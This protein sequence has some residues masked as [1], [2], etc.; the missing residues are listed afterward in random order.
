MFTRRTFDVV[1]VG[2]GVVGAACAFYTSRSGLC[3]AVVDRG[4]V[5]G[6]TTGA[7]E[8]NLLVSDKQPGPELDLAL[9]STRLW[10]E[11]AEEFPATFEYEAKGG[12]V[13][14]AQQ[15]GLAA[16]RTFAATQAAAGVQCEDVPHL[17]DVEPHLAPGLA[18]G[19][20]YPQDAQVQPALAAAHLLRASGARLLLG[21]EVIGVLR[22]TDGAVRGVR[23]PRGDL[24]APAVVNA[25]GTWG[26]QVAE[27]AGT[28]LP[29]LP[30]RGFVLVT[31]P[32]PRVVRHK[33]Y[34]ADY[35]ADVASGSAA[36]QTS[37]VVEGT[38]AG[39]VLIGASRERV[40]FD[41]SLST[42]VLGKLAR[43]AQELFPVLRGV[44]VMRTYHGFR[45]YLPDHHPAIG[46]DGRVPGLWH[47]CGHEGAGVGLAPA[48]GALIADG[49]A[50]SGG[51]LDRR[52]V[53]VRAFRPGRFGSGPPQPGRADAGAWPSAPGPTDRPPA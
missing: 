44:R 43:Q 46:A 40:G 3:V 13:V 1:V 39:P 32:L 9:L 21:E 10:R 20:R 29:V 50:G 47:A 19:V 48:T 52:A 28:S 22:T 34:A 12:L 16:L 38:A 4:P 53:D 6:G 25:A 30:R 7:G 23:T 27:L 51:R 18:G 2:A 8:G 35:V 33:V 49:L 5:A 11:L 42:E 31:E 14:A 15:D 24:L 41:R 26:G 36:L 37:A 17:A 45:P